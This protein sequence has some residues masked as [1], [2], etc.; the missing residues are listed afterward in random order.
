MT[1]INLNLE[2][3]GFYSDWIIKINNENVSSGFISF[4]LGMD[5]I[6]SVWKRSESERIL[7]QKVHINIP[8]RPY[9]AAYLR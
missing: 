4:V 2:C 5:L 8:E 3:W 1:A 9:K 6:W 7:M